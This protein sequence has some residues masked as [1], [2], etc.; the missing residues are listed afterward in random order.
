MTQISKTKHST[1]E[2][3]IESGEQIALAHNGVVTILGED[4]VYVVTR[5]SLQHVWKQNLHNI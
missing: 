2:K 4:E 3:F 1:Q 5:P